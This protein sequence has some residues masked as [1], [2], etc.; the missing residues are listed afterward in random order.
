MVKEVQVATVPLEMQK[1]PTDIKNNTLQKKKKL[2]DFRSSEGYNH[3][4]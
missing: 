4:L 1:T 2:W 3:V